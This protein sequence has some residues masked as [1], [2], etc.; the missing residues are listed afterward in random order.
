MSSFPL[1]GITPASTLYLDRVCQIH[2]DQTALGANLLCLGEV[3]QADRGF[4]FSF[5]RKNVR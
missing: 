4:F 1:V 3:S 2:G 5:S